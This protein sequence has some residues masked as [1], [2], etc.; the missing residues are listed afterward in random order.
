VER[1]IVE[2][3]FGIL[4]DLL[5]AVRLPVFTKRARR[6]MVVH[7]KFYFFDVGIF[8]TLRPMGPLD[9]P[10]EA[11]GPAL[12][13]LFFQELRAINDY[14]QLGYELYY[15]RTSNEA[16]VDFILYGKKGL[17]AFEVKRVGKM[18]GEILRGLKSFLKE[19]PTAKA[20]LIYGGERV[21]REGNIEILPITTC[22]PKLPAILGA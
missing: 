1:K 19:Y 8:R 6:R 21:E 7:P 22:L 3:Y 10:A 20:Y 15:W 11:E 4:E 17:F 2:N 12:E 14:F 16:E 9:S 18:S 13:T 5:L